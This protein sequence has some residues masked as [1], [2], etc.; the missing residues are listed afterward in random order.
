MLGSMMGGAMPSIGQQPMHTEISLWSVDDQIQDFVNLLD[1]SDPTGRVLLASDMSAMGP[2][3]YAT[4]TPIQRMLADPQTLNLVTSVLEFLNPA[5]LN[6]DDIVPFLK[7]LSRSN[8]S[9]LQLVQKHAPDLFLDLFALD[10]LDPLLPLWFLSR[11]LD[12]LKPRRKPTDQ[13][14]M[15]RPGKA[16]SAKASSAK[17]SSTSAKASSTSAKASS[18]SS[19]KPAGKKPRSRF[20]REQLD[21]CMKVQDATEVECEELLALHELLADASRS[22]SSDGVLLMMAVLALLA[23]GSWLGCT[24]TDSAMI[25][26]YVR[27][28]WQRVQRR[29][30]EARA[31][32]L[33]ERARVKTEAAAR[34][35]AELEAEREARAEAARLEA[36][37]ARRRERMEKK[38]EKAEI[39][40]R[41]EAEEAGKAR[42]RREEA[43][44]ARL[45]WRAEMEEAARVNAAVEAAEA[46]EVAR[47]VEEAEKAEA[48]KAMADE[49]AAMVAAHVAAEAEIAEEAARRQKEAVAAHA[50]MEAAREEAA[51][52]AKAPAVAG[53]PMAMKGGGR[54]RGG[55]GTG[56]GTGLFVR[57]AFAPTVSA[58]NGASPTEHLS[59][60][61]VSFDTERPES[62]VG[63]EL[64]CIVCFT[65][66]KTHAAVPCG[67]LCACGPCSEQMKQRAGGDAACPYCRGPVS[68]WMHTR[69]V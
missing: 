65:N 41:R 62:T 68:M 11:F 28:P 33:R 32:L 47:A 25:R 59:L 12:L 10:P 8:P 23:F 43:E 37:E 52:T 2:E 54:G 58:P 53:Q 4:Q 60:A 26:R 22:V 56:R 39:A 57:P 51:V 17:A 6:P 63:G 20:T 14:R 18:T 48:A 40:R 30:L 3:Q 44:Q 35:A 31:V 24:A 1:E 42:R 19:R 46:A 5:V 7:K 34:Q 64:T 67:H 13:P 45:K 66:P 50:E 36:W 49:E 27:N 29:R 61:N 69:V 55:R 15:P 16:S 21:F 38:E 9:M